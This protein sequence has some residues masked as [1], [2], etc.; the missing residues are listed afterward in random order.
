MERVFVI[1]AVV[2]NSALV[3]E[4]RFIKREREMVHGDIENLDCN[5][6][7]HATCMSNMLQYQNDFTTSSARLALLGN[8]QRLGGF[9]EALQMLRSCVETLQSASVCAGV[10]D[11]EI[12]LSELRFAAGY[13]SS[14]ARI[15][16][17]HGTSGSPCLTDY[18]K[19]GQL[20]EDSL[21][22]LQN[23]TEAEAE[24]DEECAGIQMLR[25]CSVGV[26]TSVCGAGVGA[27]F[28]SL[29]EYSSQPNV[30]ASELFKLIPD[31]NL[32]S[33]MQNCN[34][35]VP[36][37]SLSRKKKALRILGNFF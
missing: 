10:T 35:L 24:S 15:D 21:Q 7:I 37:V 27:F 8:R 6:H 3:C 20:W 33:V 26:G 17:L 14:P 18:R 12:G 13:L 2:V 36:I 1:L 29:W 25:E 28:H 23:T 4:G 34:K 31:E 19:L 22:C 16:I 9:A 30:D 11:E 32:A 5:G